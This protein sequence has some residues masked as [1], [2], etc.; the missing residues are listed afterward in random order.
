MP[1]DL[2]PSCASWRCSVPRSD[3]F[4]TKRASH[5]PLARNDSITFLSFFPQSRREPKRARF[6]VPAFKTPPKF[7]EK[8]PRERHRKSEMVAGEGKK[9]AKFWAVRRRGGPA[10][11]VCNSGQCYLGQML[12]GQ[13]YLGQFIIRII[14]NYNYNYC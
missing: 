12:L 11:A 10:E 9:R 2:V 5:A 8:T 3:F 14:S 4:V 7:H 13:C 6:G 1:C